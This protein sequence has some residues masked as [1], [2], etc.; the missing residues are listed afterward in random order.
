MLVN[1]FRTSKVCNKSQHSVERRE[2]WDL[3]HFVI[4][5]KAIAKKSS[6]ALEVILSSMPNARNAKIH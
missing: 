2:D 5:L 3:E 4:A 6:S 1:H